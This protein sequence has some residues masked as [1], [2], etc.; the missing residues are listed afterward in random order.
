MIQNKKSEVKFNK[1]Y[2]AVKKKINISSVC[3]LMIF[4][5]FS[6][7]IQ[8]SLKLPK[9]TWWLLGILLV[10]AFFANSASGIYGLRRRFGVPLSGVSILI[11]FIYIW[12]EKTFGEFD[13]GSILFHIE[14]EFDMPFIESIYINAIKNA[15]K[16][17]PIAIILLISLSY[18]VVRDKRILW[19]DRLFALPLLLLTPVFPALYEHFIYGD[20]N[21]SLIEYYVHPSFREI[22]LKEDNK[23]IILL[24]LESTERTFAELKE[25]EDIFK[26]MMNVAAQ[27]LHVKGIH[28]AANTGWTI[29]GLV[30][31]QCGVPLQPLG[32]IK[33]NGLE[34]GKEFLPGAVCISDLAHG[35]GYHT[36]FLKGGDLAF[37]G[38]DRFLSR[39]GYQVTGAL[40]QYKDI[41]GDYLNEWGLYDD[42]LFQIAEKRVEQLQKGQKPFLMTILTVGGHF[43]EGHPSKTCIDKFGPSD[44]D[45]ILFSAKCTGFHVEK[46]LK[47]LQ[48]EGLL[49]NTVVVVMSDHFV[50]QNSVLSRLKQHERMNYFT[51]VADDL[52]PSIVTKQSTM[53]DVFPTVLQ[54]MGF[55]VPDDKAGLGVSLISNKQTLAEAL[56][57]DVL[58]NYIK[59]DKALTRQL[60]R[61]INM[62]NAKLNSALNYYQ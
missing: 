25:G 37:A 27:G 3:L 42:T 2:D 8:S 11:V 58:N 19:A 54:L 48:R 16:F 62:D 20:L 45:G 5:P 61:P 40:E 59:Y 39:H 10:V 35:N 36:E 50:M 56:G 22:V 24:Y 13:L 34:A 28:Q 1:M 15:L 51:I 57:D 26:G 55:D 33:I 60:W 21:N 17:I 49:D 32:Q 6:Y 53:L 31:S 18:M 52:P 43:P 38:T 4:F 44:L 30:S 9:Y 7:M 23:N 47:N 14:L 41:V 46:F 12:Y 29:A